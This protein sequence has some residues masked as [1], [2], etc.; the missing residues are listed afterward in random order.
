MSTQQAMSTQTEA[1]QLVRSDRP[2]PGFDHVTTFDV[3][4]RFD[5]TDDRELVSPDTS[6][7]RLSGDLRSPLHCAIQRAEHALR[8]PLSREQ[9]N[10]LETLN[11]LAGALLS[12]I[13]AFLLPSTRETT[14]DAAAQSA[15][16]S[17]TALMAQLGNDPSSVSEVIRL[18]LGVSPGMVADLRSAVSAQNAVEVEA[19]AHRLRGSISSFGARFATDLATDLEAMGRDGVLAQARPIMADLER[20]IAR[21]DA[22]LSR[23]LQEGEP[24]AS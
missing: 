24:C 17:L 23:Y 18:F 6:L 4:C 9:R 14:R 20:E 5:S 16:I 11:G 19:C 22:A 10:F 8:T 7:M 3:P 15:P 2:R 21:V 12:E 13:D 1:R